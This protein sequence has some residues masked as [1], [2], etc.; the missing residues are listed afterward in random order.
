MDQNEANSI[1]GMKTQC[2]KTLQNTQNTLQNT[3]NTKNKLKWEEILIG[4]EDSL[5]TQRGTFERSNHLLDLSIPAPIYPHL[6]HKQA[7]HDI[8][9]CIKDWNFISMNK[10]NLRC[11]HKWR[12]SI[13]PCI[14]MIRMRGRGDQVG[15]AKQQLT[16]TISDLKRNTKL[17]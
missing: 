8:W 3:Q 12:V 9:W 4:P 13:G 17:K 16:H 2:F 10:I 1:E 11:P 6:D 7:Q 5:S 15:L 14:N